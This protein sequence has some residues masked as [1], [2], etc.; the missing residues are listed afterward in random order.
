MDVGQW[1]L[2]WLRIPSARHIV[3]SR[4][5]LLT[6][7]VVAVHSLMS[8]HCSCL[9]FFVFVFGL[10]RIYKN[11]KNKFG[12]F[13]RRQWNNNQSLVA[14]FF[15]WETGLALQYDFFIVCFPCLEFHGIDYVPV[16][17]RLFFVTEGEDH[18]PTGQLG[19]RAKVSRSSTT[20]H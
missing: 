18:D 12:H 10:Y 1:H 5:P 9:F 11:N 13:S 8:F 7:P 17:R 20:N 3:V 15:S 14:I 16:S 2:Y 19:W 4:N 6:A